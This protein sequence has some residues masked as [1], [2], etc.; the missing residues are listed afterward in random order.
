[1][2]P[3]LHSAMDLDLPSR[4]ARLMITNSPPSESETSEILDLIDVRKKN[5]AILELDIAPLVMRRD[6]LARSTHSLS[7][8][9]SATRTLPFDVLGQ[10]FR[11]TVDLTGDPWTL[12]YIS[13]RWRAT[14]I[15]CPE[16]WTSIDIDHSASNPMLRPSDYPLEKLQTLLTRSTTHPL[17]IRFCTVARSFDQPTFSP[18]ADRVLGALIGCSSRWM[19]V[20]IRCTKHTFPL[21]AQV[22][23]RLPIL[24]TL[25]M[26]L[27][28]DRFQLDAF[29]TAP[30]LRSLDLFG[31][32]MLHTPRPCLLLPWAQITRYSCDFGFWEDQ[33]AALESLVNVR[34]CRLIMANWVDNEHAGLLICPALRR[35]YVAPGDLEFTAPLLEEL[36]IE[37]LKMTPPPDTLR[38]LC[39]LIRRSACQLTKL[40]LIAAIPS[41]HDVSKLITALGLLP[42]LV[43]LCVQSR[44]AHETTRL[45]DLVTS[46]G[47]T[48]PYL[49]PR[50]EALT[51][52]GYVFLHWSALVDMLETRRN[53]NPT[54]SGV[55][56]AFSLFHIR[57]IPH[58]IPPNELQRLDV[59]RLAGLDLTDM[60]GTGAREA[61][62][63]VPFFNAG[64]S[65]GEFWAPETT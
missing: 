4:I 43:E 48:T 30:Q 23:G 49:L 33:I 52:G 20:F 16:L 28:L 6:A 9:L 61:M 8:L 46:L 39:S 12:S 45:D 32:V 57:R 27:C 1:M 64:I 60:E 7:L 24:R 18:H 47:A 13:R 37:P 17:S 34:E 31:S 42:S 40:C 54:G 10:I 14:A 51:F 29:D 15:E 36:V 58:P 35:L 22:Q 26:D 2:I 53:A 38:N 19:T 11:E 25:A 50:L 59:L 65:D 63:G 21:L 5:I 62:V 55:L 44:R 3:A 56:R 41:I